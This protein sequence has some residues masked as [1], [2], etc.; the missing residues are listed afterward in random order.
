MDK[1][2]IMKKSYIFVL[3]C[4]VLMLSCQDKTTS[5]WYDANT[6][7]ITASGTAEGDDPEE[8]VVMKTQKACRAA[9]LNAM[10]SAAVLLGEAGSQSVTDFQQE[11]MHFSAF[12]SGGSVLSRTFDPQ[13]NKCTVVYELKEKGLRE[14]AERAS[15]QK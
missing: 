8:S 14:K 15:R 6:L 1:E 2:K 10:A 5:E 13:S 3:L 12:I 9:R 4:F 11:G 7:R